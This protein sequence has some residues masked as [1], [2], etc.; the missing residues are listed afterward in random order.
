M[1][2]QTAVLPLPPAFNPHHGGFVHT[3]ENTEGLH[4]GC[5]IP[6]SVA[7][8]LSQIL[9]S[10][11]QGIPGAA[12]GNLGNAIGTARRLLQ[13][14]Y[15]FGSVEG[16]RT[17][18]HAVRQ[19]APGADARDAA[20]DLATS[21]AYTAYALT[22][23]VVW[24]TEVRALTQ[25]GDAAA[26]LGTVNG[27]F[28][29]VAVSLEAA[30]DSYQLH[31]STTLQ[32]QLTAA[33]QQRR[34]ALV[35]EDAL[36]RTLDERIAAHVQQRQ[37]RMNELLGQ[38]GG[39]SGIRR[40]E[41]QLQTRMQAHQREVA[42]Q[43]TAAAN[44]MGG[45]AEVQRQKAMLQRGET[46]S[47]ELTQY[48]ALER[49][50]SDRTAAFAGTDLAARVAQMNEYRALE[51]Q[52]RSPEATEAA[53]VEGL[54][55][56]QLGALAPLRQ[57]RKLEVISARVTSDQRLLVVNIAK[58]ICLLA[59]MIGGLVACRSKTYFAVLTGLSGTLGFCRIFKGG[60]LGEVRKRDQAARQYLAAVQ[61]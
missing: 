22:D 15:I 7:L 27:I 17:S 40:L 29:C 34:G 53:A 36:A 9:L 6:E 59:A 41:L 18:A 38:L 52:A 37:G 33:I 16:M 56:E 54:P 19:P 45:M 2:G 46:V 55:A 24:L 3:W 21:A 58:N 28:F 8:I 20:F 44:Q 35:G 11:Q 51:A 42:G 57:L 1:S 32:S 50:H 47:R 25:L 60:T 5:K 61:A 23:T 13:M 10:T 39:Q 43:L 12:L 31:K 48:V 49:R 4:Q 14:R 30:T 26:T